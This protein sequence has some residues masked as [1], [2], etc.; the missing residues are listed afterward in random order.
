VVDQFEEVFTLCEDKADRVEFIEKLLNF[1]DRR[2]VVITMRADFLGECTFYPELRK[3][4]ETRQ[5]LVGPMEPAEL[6]TA[7]KMQADRGGLRFEAGLSHAILNDVQGEPGVMPLLQ[8]A[9]QELWKRRRGRWL[10]DEEYQAIGRVQKAIAKTADDFYNSLSVAEQEQVQN[11]FLRLT[12]LDA[13][14]LAGEKRRDTRRRVELEDLVPTGDD[15][16]VTRK[17][18]QQLAGGGVRLVVTSRN[19]TTGKEEVE[20]AHE[21]LIRYWP[22][23]QNWLNQNR[24]DLLLRETI[25]QAA[26]EWQQHQEQAGQD[27]YLIHHGGRLEDAE[28]L[29]KHPKF[30]HLNQLE[31]EYVVACVQLRERRRKLEA[32][33]KQRQLMAAVS[34]AFVLGGFAIVAGFQWRKSEIQQILA[35]IESAEAR[36][37]SNQILDARI[38]SLQAAKTLKQSFWQLLLPEGLRNQVL[39]KLSETIYAAQEINRLEIKQKS[40]TDGVESIAFTPNGRLAIANGEGTVRLCDTKTQKC[41]DLLEDTYKKKTEGLVESKYYFNLSSDGQFLPVS[42]EDGSLYLWDTKTKKREKLQ[43]SGAKGLHSVAF[44]PNSQFLSASNSEGSAYLW[45]TKTKKL[46][47]SRPHRRGEQNAQFSPDGQFLVITQSDNTVDLEDIKTKQRYT[48][49]DNAPSNTKIKVNSVQ[50]SPDSQFL[51]IIRENRSTVRLWNTK[52]NKWVEEFNKDYW[53][54]DGDQWIEINRVEFTS[55]SQI[56]TIRGVNG[57]IWLRDIKGRW[58]AKLQGQENFS[59]VAFRPTDKL[60]VTSDNSTVRLWD[61]SGRRFKVMRAESLF[62]NIVFSPKGQRLAAVSNGTVHLWDT[63]GKNLPIPQGHQGK[64]NQVAFSLNDQLLIATTTDDGIARLWDDKGKS[65]V[66]LSGDQG[67]DI[68]VAISPDGQHLAVGGDDGSVHLGNIKGNKQSL[69]LQGTQK[70]RIYE[71][72]F[73]PDGQ[74]L[75]VRASNG[76]WH[77]NTKDQQLVKLQADSVSRLVFSPDSQHLVTAGDNGTILMWDAKGQ[78]KVMDKLAKHKPGVWNVAISPD[79]QFLVTAGSDGTT[80]LWSIK[81]QELAKLQGHQGS[82]NSVA[83]SPDGKKLAS[84][85]DDGTLRLWQVGGMDE[86]VAMNC[87]WVRDYLKNPDADLT[88]ADRPLCDGIRPPSSSPKK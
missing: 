81:G 86:L 8:Y 28:V 12:R 39:G 64:V 53:Y 51:A 54:E 66:T 17:L 75:A 13:S 60:L 2:K 38:R 45:D 11:I 40:Y 57:T 88:D 10:C 65:L 3:R 55:D 58:L 77:G 42:E 36:L 62:H 29:W 68:R 50:F 5:K 43:N 37:A 74:R 71:I 80:R 46:K 9:L 84:S 61:I 49:P 24:S 67:D 35:F 78:P 18:V 33:R 59:T 44:S 4:I 85:G 25:N 41:E 32:Q 16:A 30:V 26:F 34:A 19:E 31:A 21:A 72:V 79:G 23:L 27:T 63:E 48:L 73:S 14:A 70:E 47:N 83:F 69:K 22:T 87:D 52:T 15:L 1:A 82:V 20:V 56:L 6:I 7:M 76:V